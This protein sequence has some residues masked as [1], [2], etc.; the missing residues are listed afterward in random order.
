MWE[1]LLFQ[2]LHEGRATGDDNIQMLCAYGIADGG[3]DKVPSLVLRCG[4]GDGAAE[5]PPRGAT[6]PDDAPRPSMFERV[7]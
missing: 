7:R 1:R 4:W 2:L 6:P 5:S 3:G